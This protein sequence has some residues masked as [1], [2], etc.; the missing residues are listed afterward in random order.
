MIFPIAFP[1]RIQSQNRLD[2][3]HGEEA[4]LRTHDNVETPDFGIPRGMPANPMGRSKVR[5]ATGDWNHHL[6]HGVEKYGALPMRIK[7]KGY[8]GRISRW[9][10]A[11]RKDA[12]PQTV[13]SKQA[14]RATEWLS[15]QPP[16]TL[17]IVIAPAMCRCPE[18]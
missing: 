9:C 14:L 10:F 17:Q 15:C 6:H 5:L 13:T 1:L 8:R 11:L 18:N 12:G 3:T 7:T 4:S 2:Q 16:T